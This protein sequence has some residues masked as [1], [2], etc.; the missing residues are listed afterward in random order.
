MS[1]ETTGIHHVEFHTI[2]PD[3]LLDLFIHVYGFQLIA[4]R[5]TFNYSQWFLKSYEC[6]L[7]ISSVSNSDINNIINSNDDHYDI[8]TSI[9]RNNTTRDFI[10]DR[11]TV[12]NIALHVKSVQSI[13]DR[14]S[15]VQVLLSHRQAID[16]H[17]SIEYACIKSCIGNVVHTLIDTSQYSGPCLPGFVPVSIS[18]QRVLTQSMING[19]DHVTFAMPKQSALSSVVWYEKIL[20]MKRFIINQEDDPFQ[21]FPVRVG[22]AGMRLFASQYWKCAETACI[23]EKTS[24]LKL[25]FAESLIENDSSKMDQIR[26]FIAQHKNQAG[27]QHV[28]FKSV[29]N[30]KDVVRI[31][32]ANGAQFLSPLGNYYL[33]ENNGHVIEAAGENVSELAELGILLDDED[34][35]I[36]KSKLNKKILLQIFTKSIFNNDTFFLEFIERHGATGFGAGNIRTLWKI[37][38]Q[39]MDSRTN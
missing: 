21:G 37:V 15:D 39:Q 25:V 36:E 38:Q 22:T 32:K 5:I 34:A 11:D 19:I 20:G 7:L 3:Y 4:K 23:N 30:I 2:Q 24:N 26:T 8:L 12:F 13:L 18:E 29:N 35:N 14:N 17:G 28:G 27:V 10:L 33:N 31:T 9:I 16:Q 1:D 6:H